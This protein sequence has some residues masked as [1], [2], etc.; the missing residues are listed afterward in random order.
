MTDNGFCPYSFTCA[1]LAETS[2]F[3]VRVHRLPEAVSMGGA[4]FTVVATRARAELHG[5][6]HLHNIIS[7]DRSPLIFCM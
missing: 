6:Y 7:I 3:A 5:E 1:P 4:R 2:A